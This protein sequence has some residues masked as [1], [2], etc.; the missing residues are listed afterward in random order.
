MRPGSSWL[1]SAR[2][3]SIVRARLCSISFTGR[4]FSGCPP[5]T[6]STSRVKART[7][8]SSCLSGEIAVSLS[9]EQGNEVEVGELAAG[10]VAGLEALQFPEYHTTARAATQARVQAL[11]R[12]EIN[13][14][15]A[16]DPELAGLLLRELLLDA[17][18]A[19][20]RLLDIAGRCAAERL[21][22]FLLQEA[23]PGTEG[24]EVRFPW[25]GKARL[26]R[27]IGV[28]QETL[29]RLFQ[30]FA[31]RGSIQNDLRKVRI[32]NP[33]SLRGLLA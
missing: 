7:G 13:R 28:K 14:R 2:A 33:E 1:Q 30:E 20:R 31:D 10:R 6:L 15:L 23:V 24:L 32:V 21:A 11:S 29:S 16:E 25:G 9:T 22:V 19:R 18:Q 4:R 27:R 12:C 3:G 5:I 8:S 17:S 26:A